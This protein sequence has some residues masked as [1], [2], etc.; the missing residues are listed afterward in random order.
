MMLTAALAAGCAKLPVTTPL[1]MS[2]QPTTIV[3]ATALIAPE[4]LVAVVTEAVQR[5]PELAVAIAAAAAAAAPG[6]AS[7]IRTAVV[8][9]APAD[10]DAIV[11]VTKVKRRGPVV[12]RVDIP[13]PDRLAALVERSTR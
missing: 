9:L 11:A 4:S 10:A 5:A 6:Q 7:A 1:L 3:L 8:R 12:A 2:A 13:D